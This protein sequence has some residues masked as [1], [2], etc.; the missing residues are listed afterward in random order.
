M[1]LSWLCLKS[2]KTQVI[3]L[4]HKKQ[5]DRINIRSVPVLSSS[6]S[7][8]DSTCDLVVVIDFA[9]SVWLLPA[10]SAATGGQST[11]WSSGQDPSPGVYIPS[12][13][14]CNVLLYGI[15]DNLF[16][17]LQS[18]Q[19][20]AE[21]LLMGTRQ[22]DHI[23]PVL[24]R[25]HWLPVKQRVVF[26]FKLAIL[27]FKS[28]CGETPSYLADVCKLI[29]DSGR[30]RLCSADAYALTVPRTYTLLGD[31]SFSVAGLRVWNSLPTTLH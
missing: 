13:D 27:V 10:S 24:S 31:R 16:R 26:K 19:N 14:Y 12:V 5:T 8:V 20:A 22:C 11:S 23:S 4:G 18:I 9:L 25:L 29:A 28:L 2:S 15:T 30:H 6:V 21:R 17:R 3:W 1:S 7:V